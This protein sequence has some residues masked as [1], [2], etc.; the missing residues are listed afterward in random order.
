MS[1]RA[2]NKRYRHRHTTQHGRHP[3]SARFLWSD[4]SGNSQVSEWDKLV[5][6][7]NLKVETNLSYK[8]TID[9]TKLEDRGDIKTYNIL[10]VT[11]SGKA[12]SGIN[13]ACF[14]SHNECSIHLT[15]KVPK[16]SA[17]LKFKVV[18]TPVTKAGVEL[19]SQ[20]MVL[21][22]AL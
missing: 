4:G 5:P 6:V 1:N 18:F 10:A 15:G 14:R 21:A 13:M 8:I 12:V 11:E 20:E 7:E 2:T 9:T 16:S 3:S 19:E 17:G 22:F